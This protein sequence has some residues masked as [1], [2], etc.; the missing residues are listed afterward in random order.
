MIPFAIGELAMKPASIRVVSAFA[1]LLAVGA[2]SQPEAL[3]A[4]P[5]DLVGIDVARGPAPSYRDAISVAPVTVGQD[6]QTPW[7]SQIGPAQVQETLVQT[8]AAA[9]LGGP[10][11]RYRLDTM[12]LTLQRPYAGFAMTVTA[13]IAYR[14]TEVA[15]GAVVYSSTLSTI[16]TASLNDAVMNDVRLRIADERAIQANIRRLVEELYALPDRMPA[17]SSRRT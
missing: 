1:A 12:L 10:Q 9:R 14:L 4:R 8:L 5:P 2:C 3:S 13:T 15:T 17:T 16:G 11:G 6:T 7:R